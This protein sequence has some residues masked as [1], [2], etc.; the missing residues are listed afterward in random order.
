VAKVD[1]VCS[2]GLEIAGRGIAWDKRDG[3]TIEGRFAPSPAV[4]PNWSVWKS[5]RSPQRAAG[6]CVG[7]TFDLP[8]VVESSLVKPP[9]RADDA[10]AHWRGLRHCARAFHGGLNPGVGTW[11]ISVNRVT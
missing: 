1:G 8:R 2:W 7:G 3:S 5:R 10:V 4:A 9:L 6:L 11:S